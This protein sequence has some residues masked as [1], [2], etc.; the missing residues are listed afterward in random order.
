MVKLCVALGQE[1]PEAVLQILDTEAVLIFW[2]NTDMM[3]M[4]HCLTA[5]KVWQGESIVL[6]ILPLKGR[7]VREYI[8]KRSSHPSG[9]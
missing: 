2:H 4:I 5:A 8:A 7:Q 3:D 6:H 9:T 1:H